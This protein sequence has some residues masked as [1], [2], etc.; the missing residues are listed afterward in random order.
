MRAVIVIA[1]LTGMAGIDP[2]KAPAEDQ[3]SVTITMMVPADA[4]VSFDGAKT[5]QT[6]TL[7]SFVS[8]PIAVGKTLKYH[9]AVTLGQETTIKRTLAVHG[10]ERITLDFRGDE[11]R[12]GRSSIGASPYFQPATPFRPRVVPLGPAGR[13]EQPYGFGGGLGDG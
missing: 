10:G 11:V 7:R 12:T 8:P 9:I 1:F 4:V 13:V 3:A 5:T 6:G 2:N